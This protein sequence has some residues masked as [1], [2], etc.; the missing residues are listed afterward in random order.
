MFD[1][2][3]LLNQ[4]LGAGS[5]DGKGPAGD[6]GGLIGSVLAQSVAGVKEGATEIEKRT[7]IG[8]KMDDALKDATGKSAGQLFEDAKSMA[9]R[10]RLAA[11]AAIG[12]LG[13]LL[14]GTRTGRG[15]AGR[16]ATLGGLALVGGLAYRAWKAQQ[17]G[18][19]TEPMGQLE[20]PPADSGFGP[21]GDA[22]QDQATSL[23]ILRSMIAAAACDGLVDNEE[24][25]RIVGA[26][27]QA[28]M[29]VA[30]AKFLDEEFARPASVADLAKAASTPQLAVQ[31]YAA[32]R[33]AVDTPSAAEAA[34]LTQLGSALGLDRAQVDQIDAAADAAKTS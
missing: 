7:G 25:S 19:A 33:L 5:Q 22:A 6:I 32:A 10:N 21:A 30:A 13:A 9:D 4:M 15:L 27:Q 29:D 16:A 2:A 23:L 14:L 26:L 12:G 8:G 31:A 17:A 24:R 20:P 1:A 28:G 34:F 18:K 3:K 11:G